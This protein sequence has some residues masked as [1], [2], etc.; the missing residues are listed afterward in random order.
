MSFKNLF[1]L[2]NI[3]L[4][5]A[6]SLST[7][8]AYYSIYG[9]TAIFA[10]AVI[11]VIIMG[12]V[13]EL[14]KIITTVWL[15]KYWNQCS[16]LLKCY[17]VPAVVLLAILTSMG[18][19]GFLSKAHMEHGVSTGDVQTKLT[20]IDEKIKVQRD[21]IDYARKALEQMD[22]QV[23]A[24]L[25]RG[26]SE[27]GAERAVTI[28]RQQANE[29]NKLLKEIQ[30][31]QTNI[32][33]LNEER[34]PIAAENRKVEA[35]VGPIKYVAAMIYGD[36]PDSN[37]LERAVRY[38]IILLVIVFDPLAIALVLAANSSKEWDKKLLDDELAMS[39]KI[40]ENTSTRLF[41]EEEIQA[42]NNYEGKYKE[43]VSENEVM[44][45]TEKV[46]K[47]TFDDIELSEH[48]Y[49]KQNW[50]YNV[51]NVEKVGPLVYIPEVEDTTPIEV[52]N[53]VDNQINK[54]IQEQENNLNGKSVEEITV[55]TEKQVTVDSYD[56]DEKIETEG[57]TKLIDEQNNYML[58]NGKQVSRQA[59]KSLNPSLF[60]TADSKN[61]IETNFGTA[62][63]IQ[64]NIGDIFVRV[65]ILPN[66]VFKFDGKRWIEI[67]KDNSDSYL[68]DEEYIKY[69][70]EKLSQGEYDPELLSENERQQVENY[71]KK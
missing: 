4:L 47:E 20:I 36:N 43:F 37:L 71:L 46:A 11:P 10:G 42:L 48:A 55:D 40:P 41:T 59:M 53:L 3:T 1:S 44:D 49:L 30:T 52:N 35:E 19:F 5:V 13:L 12:S 25:S 64:A 18:I 6:L 39:I 8:A 23:N 60:V 70:I 7:V 68:H 9:L 69:L 21:N 38:V 17:L 58:F 26:E 14:G 33:S 16:V 66:K 54:E 62:F 27:S 31:A 63:P 15:K 65:D 57:V 61:K 45:F 50:N 32:Q 22:N 34:L 24:R 67:S 28:R 51:P 2:T 29:R 56:K